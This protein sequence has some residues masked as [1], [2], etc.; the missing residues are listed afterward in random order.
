MKTRV[1][2]LQFASVE[3]KEFHRIFDALK[4]IYREEVE[5]LDP[6]SVGDPVPEADAVLFPVLWVE[7]YKEIDILLDTIHPVSYTHLDVY[8]RQDTA[9]GAGNKNQNFPAHKGGL[10][11]LT[12]WPKKG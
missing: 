10:Y 11:K 7:V 3:D 12:L 6:V 9:S 1:V 5:F 2:P 8:K 4:E